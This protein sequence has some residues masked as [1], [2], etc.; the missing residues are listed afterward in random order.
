MNGRGFSRSEKSS[1]CARLASHRAYL[2]STACS[3]TYFVTVTLW[4]TCLL[5][6]CNPPYGAVQI[7]FAGLRVAASRIQVLMSQNGGYLGQLRTSIE[8]SFSTSMAQHMRRQR[9]QGVSD[10]AII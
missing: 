6:I 3:I 4:G 8:H 1:V 7:L 2:K 5:V 10:H 9:V